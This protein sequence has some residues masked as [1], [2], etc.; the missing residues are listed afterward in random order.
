MVN[1]S[2]SSESLADPRSDQ[3]MRTGSAWPHSGSRRCAFPCTI[4]RST[5]DDRGWRA[6]FHTTGIEHS[7]TNATGTG[8][9]LTPWRAVQ[10]GGPP[11][12]LRRTCAQRKSKSR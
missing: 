2:G 8:Y 10:S 6:T 4:V 12:T 7:P 3:T 5:Y 1:Q 11:L 9:E